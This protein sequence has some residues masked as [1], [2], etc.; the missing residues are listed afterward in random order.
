M[1]LLEHAGEFAREAGHF[2]FEGFVVLNG[3]LDAHVAAGG[4][5]VV[6]FRD[7]CG[8]D[9]GTESLFVLQFALLEFLEGVGEFL[10]VFFAQVAVLAVHHV[11]HVAGVDEERLAFLLFTAGDEPECHGD[12]NAVK[13]L[14]GHG[15][16]AFDKV[17]LDDA[18]ADFAFAAGLRAEC[19]VCKHEPDFSVRGEVVNHVFDPSEVRVACRREAV[20]PAWVVLQLFLAPVL[21]VERRVRHDKVESF[22]GVQV[23]EECVFVVFAE[24]RVNA[25]DGHIHFRHFPGVGVGLL[26]VNT[27]VVA[28]AAMVL[29]K[30]DALHEHAAG[31]AAGVIDAFAFARL[32]DAHDGFHDACRGVEFTALDAFVACELRDAVFVG[33]AEQILACLGIAH[34]HVAEHIH[35][36]AEHALVEVGGRVVLG[37]H[38]FE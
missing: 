35:H 7:V 5:D 13:Q 20:L 3:V 15:Y 32:E 4:E 26:A 17:C 30:L 12:G 16:D 21:E 37:E 18:F 23:L 28:V 8:F 36:V 33:A 10:D 31:T 9:D 2:L 22:G 25:A 19:S 34:V 27:Y 29:D 24:V 1:A 14:G 11:A 6:L 38:A